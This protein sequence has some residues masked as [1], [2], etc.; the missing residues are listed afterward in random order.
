MAESK[1]A[2][3][4]QGACET[5]GAVKALE[6]LPVLVR[7]LKHQDRWLR[8]KAAEALKNMGDKAKPVINDMLRVVVETAEPPLP[9]TWDDPVQLTHGELAA[10]LFGGLLRGSIEGLDTK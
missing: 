7:L 2:W 8:V 5:L 4:R 3:L 1:D 6:A 10:A 9:I